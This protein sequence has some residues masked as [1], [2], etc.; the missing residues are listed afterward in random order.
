M[1]T[2]TN[3]ILILDDRRTDKHTIGADNLME[4]LVNSGEI[5]TIEYDII[6]S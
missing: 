2:L 3:V 6:T 4:L 1:H 5:E